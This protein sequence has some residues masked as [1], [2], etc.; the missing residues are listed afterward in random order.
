MSSLGASGDRRGVTGHCAAC[1]VGRVPQANTDRAPS[2]SLGPC[3][4][5]PVTAAT[6]PAGKAFVASLLSAHHAKLGPAAAA[7]AR[8][9][10][11]RDEALVIEVVT[12]H[13]AGVHSVSLQQVIANV[14]A[15][16]CLVRI[17]WDFGDDGPER[18]ARRE[19]RAV[20]DGADLP[21]PAVLEVPARERDAGR[22]LQQ[23]KLGTPG[24]NQ[25]HKHPQIQP[26][27][28]KKKRQNGWRVRPACST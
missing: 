9:P 6:K 22:G 15:T 24:F 13:P 28:N 11:G 20:A 4:L 3:R 23:D 16:V 25:I 14:S 10:V 1:A 27:T 17:L 2:I 5:T 21:F 7:T 12:R 26:Q 19:V 8:K 18:A